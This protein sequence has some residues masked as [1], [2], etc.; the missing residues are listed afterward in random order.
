M[1][2]IQR[3]FKIVLK[4]IYP[5]ALS[6]GDILNAAYAVITTLY[7]LTFF[8]SKTIH[9]ILSTLNKL[10]ADSGKVCRYF[11]VFSTLEPMANIKK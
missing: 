5:L 10:A 4:E 1:H 9:S 8:S 7:P 2:S 11:R 6:L 3:T